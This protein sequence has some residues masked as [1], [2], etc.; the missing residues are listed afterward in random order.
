[1]SLEFSKDPQDEALERSLLGA[2]SSM[3]F[4]G[5]P[6]EALQ[7]MIDDAQAK[8]DML[9]GIID[10]PTSTPQQIAFAQLALEQETTMLE[11]YKAAKS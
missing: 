2:M 7:K 10:N 9:Q 6:P 1:M 5:A 11:V 4:G 3:V 8:A